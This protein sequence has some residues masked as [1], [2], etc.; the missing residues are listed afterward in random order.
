MRNCTNPSPDRIGGLHPV[1]PKGGMDICR[2]RSKPAPQST[3]RL[4]STRVR[5][6]FGGQQPFDDAESTEPWAV[7]SSRVR[8]PRHLGGMSDDANLC[9]KRGHGPPPTDTRLL[10]RRKGSS[11]VTAVQGGLGVLGTMGTVGV[12]QSTAW[13]LEHDPDMASCFVLLM[14]PP[15]LSKHLGRLRANGSTN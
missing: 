1:R 11:G 13:D 10:M 7:R 2:Y 3:T 5:H 9:R 4:L 15:K 8:Q 14:P 12:T 6:G